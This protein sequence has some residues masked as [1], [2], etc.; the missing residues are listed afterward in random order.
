MTVRLLRRGALA[1]LVLSLL[2]AHS[3][4]VARA[5]LQLP[6]LDGF[7]IHVESAEW[8]T[9]RQLHY[10]VR[11]E[12]LEQPVDLRILVPAD[13]GE[14][15]DQYP[16][17]Y[18][19]HGTSGRA[20]DWVNAGGAE[21]ATD[22]L[23]LIVVMPDC[24]F[25]GDGGGWFSDWFN[26]GRFG[27]PMWETFHVTQLIP[28]VDLNFRTIAADS[29]RAVAGLSQ[30]GFGS[31]SYA[32][33]H[34]DLFTSAAAFSGGCQIDRDQEAID[35][36]TTII[37]FTTAV[38]SGKD[39][40]AIFGPRDRYP[41]NWRAH[42]PATLVTNLRG[43]HIHLWTGDGA[44]GPLDPG[45]PNA[46]LDPIE[47]ITF[48]ATRLFHGHL[49]AARIPHGYTYYGAGTHSWP[50]W[51]RDLR[52]YLP[53]LMA[54][55]ADPPPPRRTV[56]Y[57][58]YDDV[59]QAFGWRV[60]L[61]RDARDASQLRYAGARGFTLTGTGSASVRTP[62]LFAPGQRVR[63]RLRGYRV[64]AT[65]L[66]EADAQGRLL[67]AV[68]LSDGRRARSTRVSLQPRS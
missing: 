44:Q 29:G 6:L 55:F 28:W 63:V 48:G 33:R 13:Y 25:N 26:N 43:M 38:L 12:A 19:F 20:A 3:A 2:L 9:G 8:I 16:V 59:W 46:P 45:P 49:E 53:G 35:S 47:V 67:L 15:G 11:S 36:S 17:L 39:P 24:G 57:L 34:P 42:D 5:A 68:P 23:P 22:G 14:G 66:V 58:S 10:R 37:Q 54:R 4:G 52:E 61:D 30:G 40:N 1:A 62:G 64:R 41:L 60:A 31:M 50:Y 21:A 32:A 18:L 27:Q 65:A 51:A 56:G 7:G